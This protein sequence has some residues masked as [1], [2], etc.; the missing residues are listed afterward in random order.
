MSEISP[1]LYFALAAVGIAL[2]SY[3]TYNKQRIASLKKLIPVL[4]G[5]LARWSFFVPKW[6]GR[7]E[8]LSVV[9]SLI[10]EGRNTPP[11]LRVWMQARSSLT[12]KI[13]R[14]TFSARLGKRLGLVREVTIHDPVF[15]RAFLIYSNQ[16]AR[17]TAHL[18][19]DQVKQTIHGLF[20]Q[21]FETLS[22]DPKRILISKPNYAMTDLEPQ[23]IHGVLVTLKTLATG[24]GW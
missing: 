7:F 20:T 12:L 10:P 9:V 8:G 6:E 1:A 22:V 23:A 11:Y 15:D 3:Q 24:S 21:G 18:H 14:E 5:S 16:P 13:T 17:A 4:G 2:V 19:N